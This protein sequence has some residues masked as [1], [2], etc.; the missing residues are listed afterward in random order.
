MQ[1]RSTPHGVL[2]AGLSLKP[3][4]RGAYY[5]RRS[6][7]CV[8]VY[9]L[10]GEGRFVDARGRT[11][12]VRAGDAL[13]MPAGTLHTVEQRPD[14]RWAEGYLTMHKGVE[15]ALTTLGVFDPKRTV[16]HCGVDLSAAEMIESIVADL[17]HVS[18]ERLPL[19][20]AKMHEMVAHLQ[21]LD[22]RRDERRPH[23]AAIDEACR[24]I[25]EHPE[26]KIDLA[27]L[28]D[29]HGLSYE[30]LRKLFRAYVGL[31][32][33]EYRIR[34]RIDTARTLLAQRG[35][36]IKQVAYALGYPDP[37]A[38]SRQF[39]QVVGVAPKRFARSV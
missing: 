34:R 22:R 36:S 5:D 13:Q 6:E 9:V 38:F 27:S 1:F 20:V 19:V 8:I 3:T 32:P 37:F 18:D 10:R 39:K 24:L 23:A 21:L 33:N 25:R 11:H 35:M 28:A 16:L 31:S 7:Q 15:K 4:M 26:R 17:R 2:A 12:H 30:R 14:G 29:R